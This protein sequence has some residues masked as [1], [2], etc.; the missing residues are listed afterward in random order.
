MADNRAEDT[1]GAPAAASGT[2]AADSRA[3]ALRAAATAKQHAAVE[4][5]EAGLRALLKAGEPIEFRGLARAAGVSVNFLYSHRELRARIEQLRDQQPRIPRTPEPERQDNERSTII[6][7]LTTKLTAERRRH[8][9]EVRLL[10]EQ[11]AAAHGELLR[12]RRSAALSDTTV[13]RED[14]PVEAREAP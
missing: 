13:L 9:E 11:L 3:A 5:A 4:R 10:R 7:T 2:A 8:H 14:V 12:L 1:T 6:R